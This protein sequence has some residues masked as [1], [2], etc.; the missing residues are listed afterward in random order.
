[1][2]ILASS[3]LIQNSKKDIYTKEETFNLT[4]G[5]LISQD[6]AGCSGSKD[7]AVST[8]QQSLKD[9]RENQH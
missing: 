1:M 4:E 8:L 5:L 9:Q 3:T 7:S 2:G 6:G